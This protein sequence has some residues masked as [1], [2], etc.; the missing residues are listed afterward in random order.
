[1]WNILIAYPGYT[2]I[3]RTT[4]LVFAST[5]YLQNET[6][7]VFFLELQT[8]DMHAALGR[9]LDQTRVAGLRLAAVSARVDSNACRISASID[10]DD[11]DVVDR[12]VRRVGALFCIDAI[13]VRGESQ[14]P[15]PTSSMT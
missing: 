7:A 10:I 8:S 9:L 15:T 4:I 5:M 14:C 2:Q 13:E 12:L 11:R 3:K 6:Y 1:M